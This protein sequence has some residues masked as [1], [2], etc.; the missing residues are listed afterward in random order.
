MALSI[1]FSLVARDFIC[2]RH[3]AVVGNLSAGGERGAL[4]V[5]GGTIQLS[6]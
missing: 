3:V 6:G 5:D 1:V 2:V 4:K